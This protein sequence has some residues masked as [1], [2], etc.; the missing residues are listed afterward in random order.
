MGGV[1]YEAN[2]ASTWGS[3]YHLL[4][5]DVLQEPPKMKGTNLCKKV[6]F[7]FFFFF[8]VGGGGVLSNQ[9]LEAL[10]T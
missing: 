3:S 1:E 8:G 7:H 2:R 10:L 5:Y 9:Y 4:A 6:L